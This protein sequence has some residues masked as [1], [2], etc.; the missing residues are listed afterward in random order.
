MR[1]YGAPPRALFFSG[2]MALLLRGDGM[3]TWFR[4]YAE[5][6]ND[7]KVQRL[8][9][10]LFKAWVNLLCL[11]CNGDGNVTGDVSEISFALR[12]P[13]DVAAQYIDDLVSAGL[14]DDL[15]D[16]IR[17]HNWD[18]RQFK[19][20]TS[21]ERVKKHREKKRNVTLVLPVT[22]PEQSRTDTDTEQNRT[23]LGAA[24][25]ASR[26][27]SRLPADWKP[28]DQDLRAADELLGDFHLANIE[29]AKFRDYWISKPGA[30]GVKLDWS[31]TWRNW[32]RRAAENKPRA[33]PKY[34]QH[35]SVLE[36]GKR[37][38]RDLENEQTSGNSSSDGGVVR[39]SFGGS[40]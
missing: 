6:L 12:V 8:P 33:G 22:P 7:P 15:D 30:G 24:K 10:E 29:A 32:C 17:P 14:I 38:M 35:D 28:S 26:K 37:M 36:I 34:Q 23:D 3:N 13:E 39:L 40:G 4:F 9:P 2:R 20:D 27:G 19:S 31:A 11:A 25:A 21:N 1:A 16:N 5:A 18:K